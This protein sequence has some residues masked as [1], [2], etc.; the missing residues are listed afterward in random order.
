MSDQTTQV[1][2]V[3]DQELIRAGFSMILEVDSCERLATSNGSVPE[4]DVCWR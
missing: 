4:S 2:L 3:D 1:L